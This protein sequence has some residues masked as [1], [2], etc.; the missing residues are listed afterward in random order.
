[1]FAWGTA[2]CGAGYWPLSKPASAV[3]NGSGEIVGSTPPPSPVPF[4]PL[5]L[6][7]SGGKVGSWVGIRVGMIPVGRMLDGFTPGCEGETLVD[8]LDPGVDP[9]G[10]G[11]AVGLAE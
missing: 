1:M 7:R 8:G 2:T 3:S 5:C 9:L 4:V 10:V 6:G 11:L